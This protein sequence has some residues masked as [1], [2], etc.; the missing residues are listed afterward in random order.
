[1]KKLALGILC[2][3][4]T[5]NSFAASTGKADLIEVFDDYQYGVTVDWDQK[6]EK[7]LAEITDAF[8]KNLDALTLEKG[9]DVKEIEALMN[10]RM[11]SS[12]LPESAKLKL[13]LMGKNP[14]RAELIK[15]LKEEG[16]QMYAQGSSWNGEA[17]ALY[18][19]GI[20]FVAIAA[21]AIYFNLTH[22]CV[23]WEEDR[24]NL[25]CTVNTGPCGYGTCG[26]ERCYYDDYCAEWVKK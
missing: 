6:D 16:K 26:Q 24:D 23:R 4:M 14:D 11:Q 2:F 21:Y 13:R 20:A 10:A 5:L 19:F 17:V 1:M 9:M 8:Y 25:I 12:K 7:K 15:F 22:A 18:G 3:M